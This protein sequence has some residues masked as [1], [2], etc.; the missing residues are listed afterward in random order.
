MISTLGPPPRY[1]LD[2]NLRRALEYWDE[3]GKSPQFSLFG[4]ANLDY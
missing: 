4:R 3:M 2:R 1:I